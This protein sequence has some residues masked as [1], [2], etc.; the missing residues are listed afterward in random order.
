MNKIIRIA[1]STKFSEEIIGSLENII[2]NTP[3]PEH[4]TALLLGI[5]EE[6]EIKGLSKMICNVPRTFVSYN[7]WTNN[8]RYSY[9][10]D[11]KIHIYVEENTDTSLINIENYKEF[12]VRYRSSGVKSFSFK[13]GE[14]YESTDTCD[15]E[16]WNAYNDYVEDNNMSA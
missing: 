7:P 16:N 9:L 8:V 10:E 1:L 3:N 12:E 5:Y 14:V 11:K 2:A 15:L 13:T 6:P 4:A